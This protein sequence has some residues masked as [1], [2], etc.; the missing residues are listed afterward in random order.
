MTEGMVFPGD[1]INPDVIGI[2][3]LAL[4]GDKQI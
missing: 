3:G 1:K 4:V 2:M